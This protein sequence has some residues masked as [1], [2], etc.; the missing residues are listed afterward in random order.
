MQN[1]N[2]LE[3]DT[4]RENSKESRCKFRS[5]NVKLKCSQHREQ[6]H[7]RRWT[8]S[9]KRWFSYDFLKFRLRWKYF[10]V[11]DFQPR[12]ARFRPKTKAFGIPLELENWKKYLTNSIC[13]PMPLE[14]AR[15]DK[16]RPSYDFLKMKPV[17]ICHYFLVRIYLINSYIRRLYG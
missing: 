8:R 5:W 16:N 15:Y 9:D 6:H 2:S 14:P 3:C 17:N 1:F 10:S 11:Q 7:V 12:C 13:E 4:F